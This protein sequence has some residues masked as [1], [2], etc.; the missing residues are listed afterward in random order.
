MPGQLRG[1]HVVQKPDVDLVLHQSGS[2]LVLAYHGALFVDL[3]DGC[4][5]LTL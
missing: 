4:H 5:T 2:Q 3:V 1:D